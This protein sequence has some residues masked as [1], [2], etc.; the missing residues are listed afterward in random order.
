MSSDVDVIIETWSRM[1]SFIAAKD[2]LAAADQL[3]AL[4]DDYD[5]LDELAEYDGHVDAQLSA[6]IKSHLALGED[7]EDE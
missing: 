6:A 1:R 2:R 7:D 4:L 3:V 5:L